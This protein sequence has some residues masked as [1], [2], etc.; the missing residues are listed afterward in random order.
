MNHKIYIIAFFAVSFG[1]VFS[2]C[3]NNVSTNYEAPTN[4]SLPDNTFVSGG[5]VENKFLNL[6]NW[7]PVNN[8]FYSGYTPVNMQYAGI[9]IGYLSN[10]MDAQSSPTYYNYLYDGP[11]PFSQDGWELLL[12][13]LGK[14]PNGDIITVQEGLQPGLP[15]IVIYNKYT[16]V[17]RVF[18][19]Y[20]VDGEG[21]DAVEIQLSFQSVQKASGL[22]RLADGKDVALDKPT[23][24]TLIKSVAKDPNLSYKWMSTD[25]QVAYDPCSCYYPSRL[26]L[27]FTKIIS[28]SIQLLG[29][30]VSLPNQPLVNN[31][32][33]VNP[34][35]F[36]SNIHYTN[37]NFKNGSV[38]YK[39]VQSMIDDYI[40]KYDDYNKELVAVNEHNKKVKQNLALLKV[41]KTIGVLIATGVALDGTP[42][43]IQDG[44]MP[45]EYVQ[46]YAYLESISAESAEYQAMFQGLDGYSSTSLNMNFFNVAKKEYGEIM[47]KADKIDIIKVMDIASKIF[48]DKMENFVSKNFKDKNPPQKPSMPTATFTEYKFDGTINT[49]LD[50]YGPKFYNPGTF[51]NQ[52]IVGNPPT[53]VVSPYEYPAYNEILGTFALLETPKIKISRTIQNDSLKEVFVQSPNPNIPD[54]NYAYKAWT[55]NYQIKL[56]KPLQYY[57][58]PSLDISQK[59]VKVSFLI[60]AKRKWVNFPSQYGNLQSPTNVGCFLDPYFT[61]NV[62]ATNANQESYAPL[63]SDTYY[64]NDVN[65]PVLPNVVNKNSIEFVTPYFD[66]DVFQSVVSAIGLKNEIQFSNVTFGPGSPILGQWAFMFDFEIQMKVL[67]DIEFSSLN[68]DGEKNQVTQLF[69][70]D[71][72]LDPAAIMNADIVP[73]FENVGYDYTKFKENLK[74][75]NT[76][77]NGQ[78]IEGCKLNGNSYTCQALKDVQID[79]IITVSNG[80]NVSILGG[81]VVEVLNNSTVSP[82]VIL[83]INPIL[84]YSQP[85][86]MANATYL[87]G[88]CDGTNANAP[89]YLANTIGKAN[90]NIEVGDDPENINQDIFTNDYEAFLFPNPAEKS[91]SLELSRKIQGV[92]VVLYDLTGRKKEVDI[93]Q[94]ET[95]YLIDLSNLSS[96]LY[97]VKISSPE[98]TITKNLIVK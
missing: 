41:A 39:S 96:G 42:I 9:N 56:D 29:G 22:I 80:Y 62:Q 72:P 3:V 20:G 75:F 79:G 27:K 44:E 49:N 92:S 81:T 87:K 25:F 59:N 54:Q 97:I 90:S 61:K 91:V 43:L 60:K 26:E 18:F 30:S 33:I 98:G 48:G 86:P 31:S 52:P 64:T 38:L 19:S 53:T 11:Q 83:A 70:Y 24:V 88:F 82:E 55:Q 68:S 10:I 84:D 15:Y 1:N 12:V 76:N 32:N 66:I 45:L 74:F 8:G 57:F 21:A 73:N 35:A 40:K 13:N 23:K 58:N 71:I 6:F 95:I 69:T 7:F 47:K 5:P 67:M 94:N 34:T 14:Y 65:A 46:D 4:N 16:G 85:M 50:T 89:K 28:Q 78:P 37:E 36:L 93:I 63:S 17:I 51:K 2:Q 77:F